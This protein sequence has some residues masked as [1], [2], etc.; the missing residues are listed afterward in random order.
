MP[1]IFIFPNRI[2]FGEGA[3]AS[4]AEERARLRVHRP[5]GATDLGLAASGL[6]PEVVASL[7]GT[8]LI[9]D[10]YANPTEEDVLA[11]LGR[12]R[13]EGCDGMVGL[14]GGSPTDAAKAIRLLATHPGRLADYDLTAGGLEKITPD[15]PPMVAVPTTAGTGSECGR[16]ALI[17]LPQTR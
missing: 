6:A 11:G 12:Y 9:S 2:L 3:R 5:R 1:T 7:D 17:Q 10:V 15:L 14:G 4:L 16:G 13:A 8:V